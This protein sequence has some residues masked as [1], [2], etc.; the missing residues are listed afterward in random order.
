VSAVLRSDHI[1]RNPE[2]GDAW[3][4]YRQWNASAHAQDS[5]RC[6]FN[7][8][9]SVDWPEDIALE[10]AVKQNWT[11]TADRAI[12]EAWRCGLMH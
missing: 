12:L 9:N 3:C 4:Y 6:F 1:A 5:T 11:V 8:L 2:E 10:F 7:I